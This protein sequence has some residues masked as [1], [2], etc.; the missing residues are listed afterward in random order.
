MCLVCLKK[1]R[2]FSLLDWCVKA[3]WAAALDAARVFTCVIGEALTP[4]VPLRALR[5]VCSGFGGCER[6]SCATSEQQVCYVK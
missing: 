2:Q 3:G 6:C 5:S 1:N 4:L